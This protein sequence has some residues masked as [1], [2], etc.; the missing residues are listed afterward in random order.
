MIRVEPTSCESLFRFSFPKWH[1]CVSENSQ[2]E[3]IEDDL[4]L[5]QVSQRV[6][7]KCGDTCTESQHETNR[8]FRKILFVCPL[9]FCIVSSFSWDLQWSQK[10]AKKMLIQSLGG[11]QRVLWYFP[12]WPIIF[13]FFRYI[14]W[15]TSCCPLHSDYQ[16]VY[17]AQINTLLKNILEFH[18]NV[19]FF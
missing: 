14:Y 13:P 11:Q 18:A 19:D 5:I 17:A 10:K 4:N 12:E 15:W 1:M 16:L 2:R 6:I 3:I 8:A 7:T 9:K